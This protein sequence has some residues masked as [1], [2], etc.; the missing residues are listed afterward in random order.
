MIRPLAVRNDPTDGWQVAIEK[1]VEDGG[2]TVAVLLRDPD[3]VPF[4]AAACAAATI[5]SVAGLVAH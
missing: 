3:V 2:V 4:G 5:R 1:V